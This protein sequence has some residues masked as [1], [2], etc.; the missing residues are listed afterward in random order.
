MKKWWKQVAF[1]EAY[2]WLGALLFLAVTS[3]APGHFTLCPLAY[4]GIE[5]CP[6]CGLGASISHLLH[7]DLQASWHS[8]FLGLPALVLLTGRIVYLFRIT[9]TNNN[10]YG[11]SN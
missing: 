8:H 6:G 5:S 7:G 10:A 1:P 4:L 11:Q 2:I 3:P 9:L